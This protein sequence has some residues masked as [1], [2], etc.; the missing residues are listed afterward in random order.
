MMA[1]KRSGQERGVALLTVLLLVVVL[2]ILI[3]ALLN[4]MPVELDQAAYTGY[5]D[6]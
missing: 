2:L 1:R 4:F 5:D 6:R 3:G